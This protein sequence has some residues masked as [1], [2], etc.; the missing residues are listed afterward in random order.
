MIKTINIFIE[1]LL[2]SALPQL[3][4]VQPLPELD[5]SRLACRFSDG[6]DRSQTNLKFYKLELILFSYNLNNID[7]YFTNLT[8][9]PLEWKYEL[10]FRSNVESV[11]SWRW[12]ASHLSRLAKDRMFR[13][14]RLPACTDPCDAN[15]IHLNKHINHTFTNP[16]YFDYINSAFIKFALIYLHNNNVI[17]WTICASLPDEANRFGWSTIEFTDT[18]CRC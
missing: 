2:N 5:F 1:P 6:W 15:I 10:P 3:L 14:A 16:H 7:E 4:P 18:T 8:T 9:Q 11:Q 13:L 12:P 17:K